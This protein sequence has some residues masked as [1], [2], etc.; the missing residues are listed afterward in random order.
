MAQPFR[1]PHRRL[2][3][4]LAA[5]ALALAAPAAALTPTVDGTISAGEYGSHVNGQ[6]QQSNGGQTWYM[7]WDATHLYLAV[8]GA[9]LGEGAVLYLDAS[10]VAP[11]NGGTNADGTLTGF[12]YDN[13]SFAALPFRANLV[14]YF[15][16]GYREFRTADGAGGWS[17]ATAGF[18]SFATGAGDVREV[19]IPWSALGAQP[20]AF[21]W[22][23]YVTSGGGYVYGQVPGANPGATIGTGARYERYY[24]VSATA[25][26]SETPP[27]SRE[28]Y[29]FNG[30]ADVSDFGAIAVYD[31]TLNSA[32][33]T[34]T[35]GSGAWTIG[36][37]LHVG[38]GTLS[39]GATADAADVAGG[40]TI[41]SGGQLALSSAIGGDL[42]VGGD[43]S[44][45]G[46][47]SAANRLVNF[48][49]TGVQTVTG[50]T[51]FDYLAVS[52]PAGILLA[53]DVS[54][55]QQLSLTGNVATGTNKVV[56]TQPSTAVV[57]TTG[58]VAGTLQKP[59]PAG[60]GAL[61]F[62]V[63][64]AS[65]YAPVSLS[66]TN[67]IAPGPLAVRT[68]AGD[69]A[70]IATSGI[71]AARSVNRTWVLTPSGVALDAYDATFTFVP[72]DLDAGATP[73]NFVV[74]KRDA[75][76]WA[77]PAVGT[78]TATSTQATGMNSFGD[79]AVGEAVLWT[80]TASAGAHGSITP[81]GA[82][83]VAD[84][85][86]QTFTVTPDAGYQVADVLVD[87]GSVGAVTSYTFNDVTANHTIAASFSAVPAVIA[88]GTAS[89]TIGAT[90]PV[91][92]VPVTMTRTAGAATLGFSVRI[93]LSPELTLAP[94]GIT[95]G[96][97]LSSGGRATNFQVVNNGGGQYTVD[98]VTLGTDC[99]P[100]DLSGLLFN[101]AVQSS[102]PS[103]TGTVSIVSTEMRNCS[104]A[105]LPSAP[106]GSA[107]VAID[108]TDPLVAVTAPNGGESWYRGTTQNITW[109]A[110]DASGVAGIALE[111]STNNGGTW[112]SIATG[113]ANDG[114]YAWTVPAVATTQA[115]VRLTATDA[116][117]NAASDE[118]DAVFTIVT[119]IAPTLAAI[120]D[121]AA[122]EGAALTFT[123][124]ATDPESPPQ[125]LT[126]SLDTGAP[127]GA[128][129]NAATGEFTWTPGEA[130]G[131]GVFSVTVRVTDDGVPAL[132]D[133][134]TITITVN[135]ANA[136]PS[137]SGVPATVTTDELAAVTFDADA[138]DADV[139][140][141]TLTFSLV[142]APAGAAIDPGTGVFSWTP[143]EA[144]GPGT[145]SFAVRV[146]DGVAN[147][148]APISVTVNE[149]NVAPVLAAIGDRTGSEG[150]ALSFTASA[151]DADLPANGLT[152]SLDT[153]APAGATINAAT[154]E[155]TW[156]PG[157][158]DGGGVFSVTVRVTDDGVPALDDFETIT[159]TVNE[160]N[161]APSL[162]GV[163]ATVTT[164][165]LAAV[166]F[167]ADATDADVPAQTLTF[168]L[169]GAPAGAAIDPGT[170]VFSWTPTEAQGPG[171]YSFAVRVTDGVA[172]TDAPISVTVNEVN[173]APVV[174]GVPAAVTIPELVAYTFDADAT[175]ADVP[176]QTLTFSLVGA[177][178]G[179]AIDP[180]TGVFSWTPTEA[181]GPGVYAF[182]V[183][184]GD[185]VTST[186]APITIT[187]NEVSI[188]AITNLAAA[189][190]ASGN[191]ADGTIL[192][193]LTWTGV[194][195]TDSV[196]IYRAPFGAYP[197]YDDA[198]GSAPAAPSF[199]PGAPWQRA[200][201]ALGTAG[202]ADDA[203]ARNYWYY[204]AVV[205][206]AG[207]NYSGVS[208]RTSG[209]LNYRLGDVSNGVAPG[210]GNNT[211]GTEDIST[212]G[213][214][215]GI[216]GAANVA[217]VAYL[218]VGPTTDFS[219][220][221]RPT[222][223]NAIDFEDLVMFAINYGAPAAPQGIAAA[224][225][226]ARA[227][228]GGARLTLE[229]PDRVAAGAEFVV[230]LRLAGGGAL[231]A[232]SAALAWDAAVAEPLAM[233]PGAWLAS[234]E[235]VAFA[236]KPG[237][238]DAARLAG[239][240]E[241]EGEIAVVRF[242]ALATGD[243]ALAFAAVR[244]RDGANRG[245]EITTGSRPVAAPAPA[246]TALAL[247]AP[248]PVRHATAIAFSLAQA[249]PVDLA[250]Y[251]VTGRRVRTLAQGDHA[252]G[253]HRV[254]WDG[255]ADD[256]ARL[257]PGIYWTRL[258]AGGRSFVRKLTVLQ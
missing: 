99:G 237:T 174:T 258:V 183:R 226:T 108:N 255:R 244:G 220:Y 200:G 190:R 59:V 131:G 116:H 75:G 186:D 68:E 84:G 42:A 2:A 150:V 128:T 172:N 63:G 121:R 94:A 256:G 214:H 62:E 211:V 223:D 122:A 8:T 217:P 124:S 129:I 80:I 191:D 252:A 208:N 213:A 46:T 125:T 78:R 31:F 240:F 155:F 47:F 106:G 242:R 32:G 170:G 97:F 3:A 219:V 130:D 230:R 222:T 153:G 178:A 119:N 76:A 195:P 56:L 90:T 203:G 92:T 185:G 221:G 138:T 179:A 60:S 40:V 248:N 14:V 95:E 103:G 166:T 22:F 38:A 96:T 159:I 110:S 111:Y 120:G 148:D 229:A 4:A 82:V 144:Q 142:G 249:G 227:E 154:G 64:D 15:K 7:T 218:D 67:V 149:V 45:A 37:A 115:L 162:S 233:E 102:S 136:A 246:V 105:T 158:A 58:H 23:G 20:G 164:D 157:E 197:E 236:P 216:T 187:V 91:V 173:V 133:F 12:T 152:Y 87:G 139:P 53:N 143:T 83:S 72:G 49:G 109:T 188:A 85:A 231:R 19:A 192:V 169:V 134:E 113:E 26:G 73:A 161:A 77:R 57:R 257:A 193:D 24:T 198:G 43:W 101:V 254:A 93:Q 86:S 69:H 132:D 160:A 10:P 21:A 156:T 171:T 199:P 151:T 251:S 141:Q 89:G 100:T 182:A 71:N 65:S 88:A 13:T 205:R 17:G 241:G 51:T 39:F 180:G 5:L 123:A 34:L 210:T 196:I 247:P 30:T 146:T 225:G 137:L 228:A 184:A 201:A 6:N 107:S 44:N 232:L 245:V 177:P 147:T 9:N 104:N 239:A 145:Y 238:V 253:E 61:V 33:R 202:F 36:G 52:N 135:E 243:P 204:V 16:D 234:Q 126:Y 140:A 235:A 74:R 250:V 48:D 29:V 98:G 81:S 194:A 79:F 27:F 35:R 163:P 55:T 176:V 11:I 175:D 50:A 167:D 209:T 181:Q 168:S 112:T 54:V 215:Y 212:L 28:S 114:A 70:Q 117:G 127:A 25:S 165:E 66:L 1:N 206:G 224:A 118:S 41:G 18:G 189:P 207:D